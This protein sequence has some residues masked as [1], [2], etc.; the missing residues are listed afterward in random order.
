MPA[1]RR[2][3]RSHSRRIHLPLILLRPD[4]RLH[5][6]LQVIHL[7]D[8]HRRVTAILL[9]PAMAILRP[10]MAIRRRAMAIR[11]RDSR[12]F[13]ACNTTPERLTRRRRAIPAERPAG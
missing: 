11:H 10:A 2:H 9:R 13:P 6:R 3:R 5:I 8:I 1:S 12:H 7:P 4:T